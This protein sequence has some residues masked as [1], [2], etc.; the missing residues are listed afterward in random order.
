MVFQ[1][2]YVTWEGTCLDRLQHVYM[3]YCKGLVCA[4]DMLNIRL[5][6]NCWLFVRGLQ[7]TKANGEKEAVWKARCSSISMLSVPQVFKIKILMYEA[8]SPGKLPIQRSSM[9]YLV[10]RISFLFVYIIKAYLWKT[11]VF[12]FRVIES[13][14]LEGTLKVISSERP[15]VDRIAIHFI[16]LL[17]A[18][19]SLALNTFRGGAS[20]ASLDKIFCC[21]TTLSKTVSPSI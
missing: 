8:V 21:L 20:M 6:E 1:T 14:G 12:L 4:G 13:L 19:A 18:P 3:I 7:R 11:V 10:F 2:S 17:R 15:A 16:R 9:R 5:K